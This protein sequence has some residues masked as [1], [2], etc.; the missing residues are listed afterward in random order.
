MA[1]TTRQLRHMV[2]T[3]KPRAYL[4][5]LHHSG[6]NMYDVFTDHTRANSIIGGQW[7]DSSRKAWHLAAKT[8]GVIPREDTKGD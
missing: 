7:Q 6:K 5:C 4:W 2:L 8:L 1:L 3:R